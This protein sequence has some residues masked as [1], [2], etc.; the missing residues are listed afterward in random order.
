MTAPNKNLAMVLIA[1][2]V[3]STG[4]VF[5]FTEN[6]QSQQT[7]TSLK[8]LPVALGHIELVAKD[9]QG[10]IIAYRQTDNLVIS[11]GLNATIN[12]L[13]QNSL[14]STN[15]S[16]IN[17]F[18]FVRVGTSG[19]AVTY[20]DSKLGAQRGNAVGGT[21]SAILSGG[22]TGMGAQIVGHWAAGHLQNGSGTAQ[23]QEAGLVDSFSNAT[24]NM[25]AHQTFSPINVASADTLDVTWK[26]T[27]SHS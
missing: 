21:V 17:K 22:G 14:Q 18:N 6:T 1:V 3:V 20:L 2:V 11:N 24:G 15:S 10:N 4:G 13:F 8:G 26:I 23:I 25:Y 19:T 7:A 16:T 27:F 12:Q 9:N 5:A